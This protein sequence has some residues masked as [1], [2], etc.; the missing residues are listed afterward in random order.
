VARRRDSGAQEQQR[1]TA[2]PAHAAAG[3][4][5]GDRLVWGGAYGLADVEAKAYTP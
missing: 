1:Q 5:N 3:I 2:L 4:V